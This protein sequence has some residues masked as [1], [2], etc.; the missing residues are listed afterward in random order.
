MTPKQ[1]NTAMNACVTKETVGC[2]SQP[3]FKILV[4]SIKNMATQIVDVQF[5]VYD[6]LFIQF[7]KTVYPMDM[8]YLV[9]N[10]RTDETGQACKND[11]EFLDGEKV[12]T[13]CEKNIDKYIRFW[14]D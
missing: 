10:I 8:A 14:W 5:P 1:I 6:T 2:N 12:S 4:D 7:K 9:S 3:D 11:L 13:K